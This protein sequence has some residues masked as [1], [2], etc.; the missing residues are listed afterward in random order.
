MTLPSIV[1]SFTKIAQEH[2]SKQA[3]QTTAPQ[4]KAYVTATFQEIESLS[5][6]VA[7]GL[8]AQGVKPEDKIAI[9][10]KPRPE[11]AAIMLGILKVGA[12]GVPLDPLLKGVEIQRLL[13]ACDVSGLL[14]SGEHLEEI[15]GTE[16]PSFIVNIDSDANSSEMRNMS[17]DHFLQ[18]PVEISH[19]PQLDD[20]AVFLN[21]SGT[22]GDA[23][24]VM[25]SHRNFSSNL[26][27]VLERL[28]ITDKD[29]LL[30][31]APWNH[32]FGLIVLMAVL[33]TGA[34]L[35]YTNDYA[36]LAKTMGENSP[37]IVVA[38]PKLFHAMYQRVE[39][40]LEKSFAKRMLSKFAPKFIGNQLRDKLAGGKLR[41]FA[42]GSAPLSPR[43]MAGFRRFGLGMIEG[44]GMT[45]STPVLTFST[46]FNDKIGSVGPPL[47]NVEL[48]LIDLNEE[49]IG[50]LIAKGPNVMLGYYKNEARTREVI[51]EDGWLHTGDLATIDEDGWL[52]IRGR[53]KNLIVLD[54]GKNVY[55]EEIEW[56]LGRSPYIEEIMVRRGQRNGVEVIQALVYPNFEEVPSE[57]RGDE[58]HNL[59]WNDIRARNQN[60]AG[61]K[62][63][64]ND[65][66]LII[67]DEPFE[68]TSLKDIKRFKYMEAVQG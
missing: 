26:S 46:E 54:S 16:I 39:Q 64:R 65:Q 34:K 40:N 53:K 35:I 36:N 68:M 7:S 42:S 57:T 21:T 32:S 3:L 62:R 13:S 22:T 15:S 20:V 67:L 47:S 5:N 23:K 9:L 52:Y 43:V 29:V 59:L 61:Y 27:A 4:G 2:G 56:E 11:F 51:D 50:E 1:D 44:Y 12:I 37:T 24:P 38:V 19:V 45:E 66:D 58:L 41:F 31:I 48:K 60:L 49:G 6:Q 30:S 25:L 63:L 10:S 14:V 28:E 8:A 55:P 18:D 17:W 33:W